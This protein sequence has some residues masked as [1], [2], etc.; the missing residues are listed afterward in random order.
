[1]HVGS[2]TNWK[3]H[4]D[5]GWGFRQH[6]RPCERATRVTILSMVAS[7]AVILASSVPGECL[8]HSVPAAEPGLQS[9]AKPDVSRVGG[10]LQALL[11][12]LVANEP[13][14]RSAILL[15]E[16]PRFRWKGAAGIAFANA[17]TPALPDDQFT[18]DS[19]AKMMTAA[20]AMKLVE[21]GT[22]KLD[23]RIGT[24]LPD[25]LM[26]DLHVLSG[27]SY[28]DEITVRQLLSHT[29]GITDDWACPGFIDLV[30]GDPQRRWKPE[31]TIAF[32][33]GNC[34]P[35]FKPGAGFHYSDT[36]YNLLGLVLEKASGKSLT[37]LYR[38]LVLDP[39]GMNH[40]YRPAYEAARPSIPGRAPAERY[41]E[42]VECGLWTSVMTA[43]W[44]GGG[45]V[46]TTED[47]DRFLRAFLRSKVFRKSTTRD[48][49][50]T[51]I[52]SGPMNNY[53]LG[54][55]RVL[56]SRSENPA[57][58]GLG[59]V[60]GHSG[61]SHNFLYYWPAENITIVGTLNQMAVKA[62]LYDTVARILTAVRDRK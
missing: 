51:W 33:K 19:I 35:H 8:T 6:G 20:I 36:G 9:V 10:R 41:L 26:K 3:G 42:D 1:V 32:V 14:V 44:A 53:G 25:S 47:L 52:E 22:V 5:L 48:T 7:A 21:V 37:A 39:L 49:M 40:T 18:I 57:H 15:V 45:L 16:G 27:R 17:K 62:K 56:F 30:A 38:E 11:D 4:V 61:S 60:W 34:P 43:D 12:D 59:E 55:S 24:Y 31:E 28:G 29:S 2:M 50:L 23:D 13:G 54:I 46:S 58:A